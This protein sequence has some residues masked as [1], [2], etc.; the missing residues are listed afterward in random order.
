MAHE[1]GFGWKVDVQE[2]VTPKLAAAYVTKYLSKEMG[3]ASWP[4]GFMRVR[5]SRNWPISKERPSEGWLW[6]TY[7]DEGTIWIE[8]H[9]LIDL[10]WQVNDIRAV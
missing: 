1:T 7:Q 6:E 8:K 9:A 2:L 10:G 3:N 5:H 4:K